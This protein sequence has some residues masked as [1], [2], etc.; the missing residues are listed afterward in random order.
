MRL[1]S[2]GLQWR[3][4]GLHAPVRKFTGK[5]LVS[6]PLLTGHL[7]PVAGVWSLYSGMLVRTTC[8]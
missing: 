7:D 5:D 6:L 4:L 2:A 3:P 8:H 1:G